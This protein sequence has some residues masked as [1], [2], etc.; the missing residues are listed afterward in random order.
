MV[1]ARRREQTG[2]CL[3]GTELQFRRRKR[4]EREGDRGCTPVCVHL[5]LNST[6]DKGKT[7][8]FMLD[9]FYNNFKERLFK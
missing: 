8:N 7:V 6:L 2:S 9:V 5:V 3:V 4:L 1:V